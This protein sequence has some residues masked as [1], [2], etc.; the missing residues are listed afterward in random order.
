MTTHR[1][2]SPLDR[3][4]RLTFVMWSVGLAA[5]GVAVLWSVAGGAVEPRLPDPR[6]APSEALASVGR[7]I[8]PLRQDAFTGRL[9]PAPPPALVTESPKDTS[10]SGLLELVAISR[11]EGEFVA[12]IYDNG[13]KRL[14]LVRSGER[15]GPVAV[16]KVESR[17]VLLAEGTATRSLRLVPPKP[18]DG[19]LPLGVGGGA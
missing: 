9:S 11:V 1:G 5:I 15:I 10:R 8:E 16:T 6:I 14:H 13:E 18:R 3:L 17:E 19:S 12:A 2:R 4:R 7:P